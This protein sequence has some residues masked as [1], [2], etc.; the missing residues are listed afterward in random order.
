MTSQ[1]DPGVGYPDD[2]SPE[3]LAFQ[4]LYG[5]WD[6]LTPAQARELF[7]PIGIAWWIAGGYAVEA[8]SGVERD[9]EDIDVSIFRRDVP[10]LRS[11]LEG[12]LHLWSAGSGALRPISDN[13]PEPPEESD[14]IWLRAHALAPWRVDVVLNRDQAGRWLSRRDPSFSAPLEQVTW[15]KDGIR[16]LNPEIALSFKAKLLRPK[17]QR[18]FDALAPVLD[19]A[20]TAWLADFLARCEPDHPWRARL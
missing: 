13:H 9:H 7:E 14:Q 4:R 16:Y 11:A 12:R 8:F 3:E 1:A 20:Q 15:T 6:P 2:L 10:A 5:P 18:D 19:A 17:D